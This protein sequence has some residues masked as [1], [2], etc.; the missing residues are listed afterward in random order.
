MTPLLPLLL[1]FLL[2]SLLCFLSQVGIPRIMAKEASST[3]TLLSKLRHLRRERTLPPEKF[4][5]IPS[6][7]SLSDTVGQCPSLWLLLSWVK[8]RRSDGP[9]QT[10]SR[11]G[12]D[13]QIKTGVLQ[14][15]EKWILSRHKQQMSITPLG[16]TTSSLSTKSYCFEESI[17]RNYPVLTMGMHELRPLT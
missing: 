17:K 1:L 10:R 15:E 11:G 9:P 14:P 7:K 13:P 12:T 16:Q 2:P 3:S 5:L 8:N 6:V 4:Q